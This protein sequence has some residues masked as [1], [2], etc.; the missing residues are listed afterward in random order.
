MENDLSWVGS[1]GHHLHLPYS[2]S[3][4]NG[5]TLA[6]TALSFHQHPH[7]HRI[8]LP[9][10]TSTHPLEAMLVLNANKSSP[11]E[12]HCYHYSRFSGEIL[13]SPHVKAV[14]SSFEHNGGGGRQGIRVARPLFLF[15]SER[16]PLPPP[17]ILGGRSHM[18]SAKFW[19]SWTPLSL[20]HSRN[21]SVLVSRFGH[22]F[23][24]PLS[25]DV[26]C[27]WPL[28]SFLSSSS[29]YPLSISSQSAPPS[30]SSHCFVVFVAIIVI[31]HLFLPSQK[32][33]AE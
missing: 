5:A 18:N 12:S 1:A 28:A 3:C 17:P 9:S 4:S 6:I 16:E 13:S 11:I 22:P 2:Y 7:H 27:E 26:I 20:S 19:D 31:H 8:P 15:Q 30:F 23:S 10:K 32:S 25:E 21:L 29:I 24:L 14:D 33:L